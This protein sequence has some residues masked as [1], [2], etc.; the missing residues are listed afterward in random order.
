MKRLP[1]AINHPFPHDCS[2]HSIF[3]PFLHAEIAPQI[4]HVRADRPLG[5]VAFAR[6]HARHRYQLATDRNGDHFF[7]RLNN[8]SALGKSAAAKARVLGIFMNVSA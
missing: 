2:A 1:E 6:S 7:P 4:S 8:T 5:G 3:C